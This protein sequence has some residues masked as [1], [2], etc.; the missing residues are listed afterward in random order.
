[1]PE[2]MSVDEALAFALD[3]IGERDVNGYPEKDRAAATLRK[4]REAWPHIEP[5]MPPPRADCR[6]E[7]CVKLRALRGEEGA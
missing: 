5:R 2:P 7:V 3:A 4:L 1:M 6:C